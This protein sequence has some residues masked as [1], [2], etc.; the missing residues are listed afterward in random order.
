MAR[1]VPDDQPVRWLAMQEQ[2]TRTTQDCPLRDLSE[3][4][5]D[6]HERR[7]ALE[8]FA[9]SSSRPS[10]RFDAARLF[11]EMRSTQE[12]T[13]VLE[14]LGDELVLCLVDLINDTVAQAQDARRQAAEQRPMLVRW[15]V[16]H[17][18]RMLFI[19]TAFIAPVF[20]VVMIIL[21]LT[22]PDWRRQ[23][24][25]TMVPFSLLQLLD[26]CVSWQL[27]KL[28]EVEELVNKQLDKITGRTKQVWLPC[29]CNLLSSEYLLQCLWIR[30]DSPAYVSQPFAPELDPLTLTL[31]V[32]LW[33]T[34]LGCGARQAQAAD[35]HCIDCGRAYRAFCSAETSAC[36]L[37]SAVEERGR[38]VRELPHVV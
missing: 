12:G 4:K 15:L 20:W 34:C 11:V 26:H 17:T 10:S 32:A 36:A 21:F 24:T 19:F 7:F 6:E 3:N 27:R 5:P 16:K 28:P 38:Q 9:S 8:S 14:L 35:R 2:A 37:P 31:R 13:R 22:E 1:L 23:C 25:A 33:H 29:C 30:V 18:L